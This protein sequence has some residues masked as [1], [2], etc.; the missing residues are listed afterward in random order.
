[1]VLTPNNHSVNSVGV[2]AAKGD[3]LMVMFM[4]H[5]KPSASLLRSQKP[6]QM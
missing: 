2:Q 3:I 5:S 6:M 1:M 4:E